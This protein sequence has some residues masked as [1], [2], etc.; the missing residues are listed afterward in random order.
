[1]NHARTLRQ[2]PD[3]QEVYLAKTGLTSIVFELT[4]RA[5]RPEHPCDTDEE[6]LRYHY[7]DMVADISTH[8]VGSAETTHVWFTN[9]VII[10]HL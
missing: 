7:E 9:Q 3:N 6:A 4:E 2:V 10:T 8:G 5:A 1:M